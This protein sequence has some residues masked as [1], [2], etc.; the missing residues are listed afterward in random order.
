[1]S[2]YISTSYLF[3]QQHP[4]SWV[5]NADGSRMVGHMVLFKSLAKDNLGTTGTGSSSS[6]ATILGL[7][8][9]GGTLLSNGR[10]GAVIEKV[11][12]G[13]VADD[14]GHLLPGMYHIIFEELPGLAHPSVQHLLISYYLLITYIHMFYFSTGDEVL[15]WNGQPLV[16][17]SYDE[18]QLIISES[19]LDS[20]VELRVARSLIGG[21][22]VSAH[23]SDPLGRSSQS[24]AYPG[25]NAGVGVPSKGRGPSVTLSDPLGGT[26]H[27]LNPHHPGSTR[28]QVRLNSTR[29]FL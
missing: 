24:R 10:I 3:L 28:I 17:K 21:H 27:M 12:K 19:R 14:I 23:P 26:T 11:K 16:G 13:S 8:V 1:M 15:E 22:A 25:G 18:V 20:Q 9:V 7:K 6:S 2:I 29:P 5:P 4:V